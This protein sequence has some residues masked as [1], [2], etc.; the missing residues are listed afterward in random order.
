MF[1][2]ATIEETAYFYAR[3]VPFSGAPLAFSTRLWEYPWVYLQMRKL[4]VVPPARILDVGCA[5]NPF[6]VGLAKMGYYMTGLDLYA[7]D[8][9]RNP[10]PAF[11]GFDRSLENEHLKFCEGSM[12]SIPIEKEH[13]D[14]V[15]CISNSW[16]F[17]IQ[18]LL[19]TYF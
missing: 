15:I 3:H 16:N 2:I 1:S 8:D 13:F 17:C 19:F 14:C 4:G 11:G 7:C 18:I 10:S 12:D 5:S 9:P 6:M